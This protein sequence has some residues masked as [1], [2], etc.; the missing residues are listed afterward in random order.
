MPNLIEDSRGIVAG[1]ALRQDAPTR[2][3][4]FGETRDATPLEIFLPERSA[5]SNRLILPTD[6]LLIG[7]GLF[8]AWNK[9][10]AALFAA[11]RFALSVRNVG[12]VV[13]TAVA[14]M[15]WD[16]AAADAN[17]FVQYVAGTSG[18]VFTFNNVSKSIVLTVTGLAAKTIQWKASMSQYLAQA[19][20]NTRYGGT[21]VSPL[22]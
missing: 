1:A 11:G 15:E 14:T 2:I 19:I 10:D 12:G 8:C 13:S 20:Q 16:A 4:W 21:D 17:P 7:Q 6:T 3:D 5:Q 22:L 9:T 18:L